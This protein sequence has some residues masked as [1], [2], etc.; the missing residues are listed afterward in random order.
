M[1]D[2]ITTDVKSIFERQLIDSKTNEPF[3]ATGYTATLTFRINAGTLKSR[4][5]SWRTPET[6]GVCYYE[7]QIGDLDSPG[8]VE[9]DIKV[10][11]AGT[12]AI[13]H[14]KDVVKFTVREA[15][16]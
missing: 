10:Y 5:M 14:I 11:N 15:L 16:D 4:T 7:W 13:Y 1:A 8:N 2:F 3:D 9:A 6:S 12:G